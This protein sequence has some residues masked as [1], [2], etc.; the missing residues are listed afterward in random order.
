M[1]RFYFDYISPYAY[2]ASTQIESLAKRHGHA[3]VLEPVLFAGLLGASGSKGPA[4]IPLRREYMFR[5]VARLASWLEV[6]IAPPASHPFNPLAALR[7]TLAAEPA[8]RARLMHALFRAAWV[9]SR[10]IE[11]GDTVA[12]IA[13]AIGLDGAA[14]LARSGTLKDALRIATDAAVA[15]KVFGVPTFTV[16]GELFWG[17][18]SF[19][20]LHRFLAGVAPPDEALHERFLALA[21]TA[22]RR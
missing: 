10:S 4:E 12:G 9:E 19:G 18:D 20:L 5:D 8:D 14:L 21:P 2:L 15:A 17:V 1:I 13:S 16:N 22:T 11:Q 3:L 6:P 7:I